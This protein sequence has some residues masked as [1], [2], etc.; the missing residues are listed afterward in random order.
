MID[1]PKDRVAVGFEEAVAKL[2]SGRKA[3]AAQILSRLEEL[4]PSLVARR[5]RRPAP[6]PGRTAR[7]TI[8]KPDYMSTFFRDRFRCRYCGRYTIFLPV[9][10]AVSELL[11]VDFPTHPNWAKSYCH[12]VYWSH[13]ATLEHVE[14][15]VMTGS[16]VDPDNLVTACYACQQTKLWRTLADLGWERHGIP[17]TG[18]DGLTGSYGE[19]CRVASLTETRKHK[20][21]LNELS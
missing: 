9:L 13:A 11:P 5:S 16:L 17:T 18:R 3:E 2:L 19:L 4:P 14:P 20:D 6:S 21:W 8:A 7:G 12:H 1:A 15:L 10:Q